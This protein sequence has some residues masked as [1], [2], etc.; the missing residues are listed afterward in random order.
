MVGTAFDDPTLAAL[1]KLHETL[2]H[3]GPGSED[4]SR[5]ILAKLKPHLPA[6]PA[7]VDM[8]CGSGHAAFL[9][10]E[11]LGATVTGI[12]LYP[13]FIA[14]LEAR[15]AADPTRPKVSGK[16]ADMAEPGL[17]P[18]CCDLLWSEGAAYVVGFDRALHAW[19]GLLR[20]GGFLVV[21]ECTWLA[22]DPPEPVRDYFQDAYP[23]ML[24]VAGC[25][26]AA[27]A[28]GYRFVHAEALPSSA[29][30]TSY[31]DPLNARIAA[32]KPGLA[33]D[34]PMSAVIAETQTEQDMLRHYG[35]AFGYVF[36]VLQAKG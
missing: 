2:N 13:P 16:I 25:L 35:D 18:Y 27:E 5:A 34:D 23:G 22:A 14:E 26:Q 8:G 29:W 33:E 30:W 28:R 3:K 17:L 20:P 32:L 15:Q 4:L 12:D 31:Y 1:A 24:S 10:A 6:N 7:V 19:K 9:L 11:L 36:Y 21:S